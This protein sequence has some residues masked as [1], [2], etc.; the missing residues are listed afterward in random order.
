VM[1]LLLTMVQSSVNA[2]VLLSLAAH[3]SY[4]G[5][6]GLNWPGVNGTPPLELP[7]SS[8]YLFFHSERGSSSSTAVQ[9]GIE[10]L[11]QAKCTLTV[12]PPERPPL[13]EAMSLAWL[14]VSC[15]TV[16]ATI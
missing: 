16:A 6:A 12:Q 8:C 14:K 5:D 9:W 2:T 3:Y 11:V 10:V 13:P 15:T 4:S 1:L 7:A